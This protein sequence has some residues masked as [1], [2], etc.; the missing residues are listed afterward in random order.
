MYAG[1]FLYAL[2]KAQVLLGW[3]VYFYAWS[4]QLT[5]IIVYDVL[6]FAFKFLVLDRCYKR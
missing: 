4:V 1:Y 6:F 5:I 3:W 2:S